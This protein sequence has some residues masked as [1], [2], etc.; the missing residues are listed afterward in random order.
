MND[1]RGRGSNLPF[2]PSMRRVF[3]VHEVSRCIGIRGS[4]NLDLSYQEFWPNEAK[5]I[6]PSNALDRQASE[7]ATGDKFVDEN[8]CGFRCLASA[9]KRTFGGPYVDRD[10]DLVSFGNSRFRVHRR[11]RLRRRDPSP[12]RSSLAITLATKANLESAFSW[13]GVR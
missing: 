10:Q 7:M 2:E 9:A 4:R 1:E 5:K 8:R 12:V 6:N 13:K 11:E 3:D